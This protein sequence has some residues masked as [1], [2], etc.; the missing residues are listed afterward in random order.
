[1]MATKHNSVFCIVM[2]NFCTSFSLTAQNV[3]YAVN[4]VVLS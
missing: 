3:I 1:M 4:I 2:S